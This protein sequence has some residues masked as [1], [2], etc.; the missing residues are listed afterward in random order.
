MRP[1]ALPTNGHT[2]E[3]VIIGAEKRKTQLCKAQY[4]IKV[5]TLREQ[6]RN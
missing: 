6:D 4:T 3:I 1:L 2:E 5:F